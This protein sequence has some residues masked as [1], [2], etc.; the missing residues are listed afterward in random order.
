MRGQGSSSWK[1]SP[2]VNWSYWTEVEYDFDLQLSV[3]KKQYPRNPIFPLGHS[4]GGIMWTL[5][6]AKKVYEKR[7]DHLSWIRAYITVASGSVYYRFHPSKAVYWYALKVASIAYAMGWF[8][9][10]QNGFGNE[11][12]AKDFMLDWC[13]N[14]L[15]GYW[16][17]RGCPIP[18][19]SQV[20]RWIP[21]AALY[22]SIDDDPFTPPTSAI[23][24]SKF[25]G[26]DKVQFVTLVAKEEP[27]LK[28]I[29]G[30]SLHVRWART[31]VVFPHVYAFVMKELANPSK[32][33]VP[34]PIYN[35]AKL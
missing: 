22:V 6:M 17:P 26:Q 13:H 18:N 23:E 9:G 24:M 7:E 33:T 28:N 27:A 5:W 2:E 3:L 15:F 34:S 32:I 19:I 30:P 21:K 11:R 20:Y 4:A 29:D 1:A 31:D 10:T 25:Y 35:T 16:Q 8:P 14:I 12:E